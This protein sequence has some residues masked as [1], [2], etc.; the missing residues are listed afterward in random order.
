VRVELPKN[1]NWRL[2]RVEHGVA[3]SEDAPWDG[4][5]IL[6]T[7]PPSVSYG[8]IA[9]GTNLKTTPFAPSFKLLH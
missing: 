5:R 4:L 8:C 6:I 1:G 3:L 9:T 7:E 2:R